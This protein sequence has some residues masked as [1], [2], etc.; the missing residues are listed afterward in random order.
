[1]KALLDSYREIDE[2]LWRVARRIRLLSGISPTAYSLEEVRRTFAEGRRKGLKFSYYPVQPDLDAL[3]AS[4]RQARVPKDSL[5]EL[6]EAK[7]QELLAKVRMLSTVGTKELSV[8]CLAVYG[9]PRPEVL[10]EAED[11]LR[12]NPPR[13]WPPRDISASELRERFLRALASRGLKD[14]GVV[15]RTEG[16][17]GVSLNHRLRVIEVHAERR[18]SEAD[19]ARL[20]V[21]EIDT[22]ILRRRRA[23]AWGLRL[24]SLGTA[25]YLLTEEGLAVYQ[26]AQQGVLETNRLR[27][28]AGQA[29]A[30]DVALSGSLE[31]VV[32]CLMERGFSQEEALH[33]GLRVKRGLGRADEPG[34]FTKDHCYFSGFCA[35]RDY[36]QAGGSVEELFLLGKVSLEDMPLLKRLGLAEDA[37]RR[38]TA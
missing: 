22:H 11:F 32:H 13:P 15:M 37:Q 23:E 30:V 27:L 6:Y 4:L 14:W 17:V 33:L 28:Y 5:G 24:F 10:R 21:H 31:D 38:A 12:E 9:R 20:I 29:L 34:A 8:H 7:R 2:S 1:M 36:A 3:E 26:E 19:V 16:V 25:G 18:F 35:V